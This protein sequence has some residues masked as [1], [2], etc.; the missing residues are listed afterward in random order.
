M[1][2]YSL[3]VPALPGFRDVQVAASLKHFPHDEY[4][5]HARDFRDGI[6]RPQCEI[7]IRA[8]VVD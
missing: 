4:D 3:G 8:L 1:M 5:Q 2:L 6:S 7:K